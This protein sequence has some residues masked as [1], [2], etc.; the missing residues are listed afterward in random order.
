MAHSK[1]AIC[2]TLCTADTSAV[3][4]CMG[5]RPGH[6]QSKDSSKRLPRSINC[7]GCVVA[8]HNPWLKPGV[9]MKY[10][11][12]RLIYSPTDL[13]RYLASPFASWMDRY[14][15]ENPGALSPDQPTEDSD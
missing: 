8:Y 7:N 5:N 14:R 13:I 4:C 3:S 10:E 12:G 15:L 2:S 6:M 9:L 11:K 1:T